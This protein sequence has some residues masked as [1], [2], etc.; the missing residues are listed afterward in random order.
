MTS[1]TYSRHFML[2]VNIHDNSRFSQERIDLHYRLPSQKYYV[3]GES[4]KLQ[5]V[6]RLARRHD[7]EAMLDRINKTNISV[8]SRWQ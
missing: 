7:R 6:D 3:N 1:V 5:L 4:R 8:I 2:R